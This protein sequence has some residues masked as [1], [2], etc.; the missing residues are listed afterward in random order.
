MIYAENGILICFLVVPW[1]DG[2]V[3]A[4]TEL[5]GC[6]TNHILDT[7]QTVEKIYLLFC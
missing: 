6:F 7:S 1:P 5:L 2:S 3:S 4:I